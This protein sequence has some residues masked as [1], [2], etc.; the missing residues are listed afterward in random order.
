MIYVY[1][2]GKVVPKHEAAPHPLAA[3]RPTNLMSDLEPFVSPVDW[4]VISSRA[5]RREHNKR[6][7]CIDIGDD[8]AILRPKKPYEPR[9]V[10]D[11][12][13]RAIDFHGG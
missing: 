4:T 13:R 3:K 10:A 9:G 2:D 6:H 11:D 5:E 7:Q 8:P 12:I 1:R